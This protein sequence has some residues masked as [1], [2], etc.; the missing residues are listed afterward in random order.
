MDNFVSHFLTA[1]ALVFVIEGLLY[2]LFPTYLQKVMLM[3]GDL[4][5][6][7]LRSL[8]AAMI[9]FGVLLVWIFQKL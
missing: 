6:Q 9:A 8:G 1:C 4:T 7:K 5:A 2:A 3:V